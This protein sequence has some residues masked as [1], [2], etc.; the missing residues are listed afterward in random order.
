MPARV[1]LQARTW[2]GCDVRLVAY[3]AGQRMAPHAHSRESITL[4]LRGE[5][6]ERAGRREERAAAMSVVA[7][8]SFVVHEDTFGPLGAV[9][10]QAELPAGARLRPRDDTTAWDHAGPACRAMVGLLSWLD[11]DLVAPTVAPDPDELLAEAGASVHPPGVSRGEPP[12]WLRGVRDALAEDSVPVAVLARDADVHPVYLA[13]AFREQFGVTPRAYRNRARTRRA[14]HRL[15]DSRTPLAHVALDA[16]YSDQ[17]HM[18]RDVVAATGLT[19]GT[20]RRLAGAFDP[21]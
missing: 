8:G 18:S 12:A 15:A 14:V 6:L 9:T 16:G 19:P 20:L 7:K 5:F 10:L 21:Q 13:R 17:P 11:P 2:S 1:V 4:V 3:P